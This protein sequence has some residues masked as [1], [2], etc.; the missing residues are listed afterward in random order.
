MKKKGFNTSTVHAATT[1]RSVKYFN[2][3]SKVNGLG[4][5]D[6]PAENTDSD[7]LLSLDEDTSETGLLIQ[8]TIDAA[9]SSTARTGVVSY[10]PN[11]SAHIDIV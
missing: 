11:G 8:M 10:Q 6:A 5:S 7:V 1:E 3:N 2:T 4:N 9:S